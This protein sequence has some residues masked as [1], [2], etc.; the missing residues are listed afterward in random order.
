[1]SI[2]GGLS[3][4][5]A[6]AALLGAAACGSESTSPTA[7][8]PA[9]IPRPRPNIIVIMA[10]DLGYGDL[11]SYG[12]WIDTPALDTMAAEGIR[13]TD[14]H[15]SGAVCSPTRAGLLTGRYQ[16]RAGLPDVIYA[17]PAWNRHHGL[18][19]EE[20]TIAELLRDEGYATGVVGKWHLGYD[21]SFNPTRHG[22]DRFHG[23]VSG[24][25][26]YVSHVDGFGVHDWWTGTA[27]RPEEGYVT[28]VITDHAVR[29]I[30]DH[31]T[32]AQPFFL[33]VAH[34]APHFPYQGPLDP[35][36]R[37]VG[38]Q[39]PE[40]REPAQVERAYREMVEEMDRG[41]G[42]ILDTLKELDIDQRTF[43][44]FLSDNG[45]RPEGSN[46]PLR[47]FK[48]S[49]WEGGHRVPAI[50]WWPGVIGGGA[51]SDAVTISLDVAATV[52][53]VADVIPPTDRPLDGVSLLP[54]VLGGATL[55]A[56]M[57][58]WSYHPVRAVSTELAVRD[59]GWK[60]VVDGN[61][62]PGVALY[63]LTSDQA[64]SVDLAADEP[65]RVTAMRDALEAWQVEVAADAT[66]QPEPP[67]SPGM[68]P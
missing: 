13:F 36:F 44:F 22:F 58:F 19:A 26:D 51:T 8:R 17:N 38:Q 29:F 61:G 39:I 23:Y 25:V 43:V 7:E 28:H 47:G 52:L 12:G 4:G 56:R 10:D 40:T 11:S 63:N 16:Q 24:N 50:A 18:Q 1:M 20:T 62:Q 30:E 53:D 9:P 57:L 31:A 5:L 41:I 37:V 35:A 42:V 3:G 68:P 32:A 59:D 21:E 66:P 49:V 48:A 27:N 67:F 45:A 15:S 34:E 33:Y 54:H 64:E 46:G 65:D 60:L 2:L 6:V 14:F 55:T